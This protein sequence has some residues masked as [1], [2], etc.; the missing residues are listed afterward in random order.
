MYELGLMKKNGA[1]IWVKKKLVARAVPWNPLINR[2]NFVRFVLCVNCVKE[3]T[4]THFG[5]FF[6]TKKYQRTPAA[7]AARVSTR[8]D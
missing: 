4:H 2:I 1:S 3:N 8:S 7:A 6:E 5:F